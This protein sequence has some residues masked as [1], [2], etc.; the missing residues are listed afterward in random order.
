MSL[1]QD[2]H[3]SKKYAVGRQQSRT[4]TVTGK[5][6]VYTHYALRPFL[7]LRRSVERLGLKQLYIITT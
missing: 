7:L 2:D 1:F 5:A 4:A 3:L 6:P